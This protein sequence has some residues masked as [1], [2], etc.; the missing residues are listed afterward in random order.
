[1]AYISKLMLTVIREP[2]RDNERD[3]TI[4]EIRRLQP[5][6]ERDELFECVSTFCG[7]GISRVKRGPI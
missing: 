2:K 4:N 6:L 5:V 1:M 3:G 7:V